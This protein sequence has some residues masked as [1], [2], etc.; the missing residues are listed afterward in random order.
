MVGRQRGQAALQLHLRVPRALP[1]RCQVRRQRPAGRGGG[2]GRGGRASVEW[3]ADAASTGA[4]QLEARRHGTPPRNPSTATALHGAHFCIQGCALMASRSARC[5]SRQRQAAAG[6]GVRLEPA[7]GAALPSTLVCQP[8]RAAPPRPA[9]SPTLAWLPGGRGSGQ[10]AAALPTDKRN[11]GGR[12]ARRGQERKEYAGSRAPAPGRCAARGSAGPPA[13]GTAAARTAA[14]SGSRATGSSA[15]G[16]C[17]VASGAGAVGAH[18]ACTL[19][20]LAVCPAVHGGATIPSCRP[21]R[22][23]PAARATAG[24]GRGSQDLHL[25]GRVVG[26]GPVVKRKRACDPAISGGSRRGLGAG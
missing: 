23:V 13:R 9:R 4:R 24:E 3:A 22:T 16:A 19:P 25:G 11:T 21:R 5:S 20:S 14:Q 17:M 7:P 6:A 1:R 2:A 8:H 12:A 15:P 10:R 26:T 18:A